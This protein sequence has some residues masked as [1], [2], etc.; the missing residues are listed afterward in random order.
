M[1]PDGRLDQ[2]ALGGFRGR[3]IE[4]REA[5][6]QVGHVVVATGRLG[7]GGQQRVGER[8]GVVRRA[9][10]PCGRYE[11]VAKAGHP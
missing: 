5:V 1:E 3:V 10:P 2:A 4:L 8:G 11:S 6:L 9:E 7:P